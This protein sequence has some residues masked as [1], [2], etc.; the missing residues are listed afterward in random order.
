MSRKK[1]GYLE[2]KQLYALAV[3][4]ARK[5]GLKPPTRKDIAANYS[6]RWASPIVT[7]NASG[8]MWTDKYYLA[9]QFLTEEVR[10]LYISRRH[11][12]EELQ[13]YKIAAVERN[14]ASIRL[15]EDIHAQFRKALARMKKNGQNI[16]LK[17]ESQ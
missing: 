12:S 1:A 11:I 13:G 6:D 10:Y 7:Q 16:W 4:V 15:P 5:Y 14:D 2:A 17:E 8:R 9:F 3:D